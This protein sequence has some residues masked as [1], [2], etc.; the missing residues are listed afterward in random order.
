VHLHELLI[1]R[2]SLKSPVEWLFY[3]FTN[4]ILGRRD[5]G[6]GTFQI[7]VAYRTALKEGAGSA[8]CREVLAE[9]AASDGFVSLGEETSEASDG[10]IFG[11]GAWSDGRT[12]R[13][14]WYR[15]TGRGLILGLYQCPSDRIEQ[16][17]CEIEEC[18]AIAR[19]LEFIP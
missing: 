7:S 18:E 10:I 17:G 16:A 15:L 14:G 2:L 13:R 1:D 8:E 6:I 11:G 9:F 4:M 5:A 3:P 12:L 19:T